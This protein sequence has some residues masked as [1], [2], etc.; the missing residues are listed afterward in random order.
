MLSIFTLGH[1]FFE[2]N[3]MLL[4]NYVKA[5]DSGEIVE[6]QSRLLKGKKCE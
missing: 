5:K 4:D 3:A 2:L 6:M 1:T